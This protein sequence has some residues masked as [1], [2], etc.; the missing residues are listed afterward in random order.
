MAV[1]RIVGQEQAKH[2]LRRMLSADRLPHALLFHGPEGVGKKAMAVHLAMM[3]NCSQP[4]SKP[5]GTCKTCRLFGALQH[6]DLFVLH[7][8]PS[9]LQSEEEVAFLQA[10]AEHP[11]RV[12]SPARNLT[13]S[14]ERVRALQHQAALRPY[15]AR[16][17]VALIFDADQMRP[18]GANALLKT[19]EDPPNEML[20]ILTS[21]Y[22]EA[23]LPTIRSRCQWIRLL[24]LQDEEIERMLTEQ[25]LEPPQARLIARLAR[26]NLTRAYDLCER[27]IE[28]Y[29]GS[30]LDFLRIALDGDT[31]PMLS[32]AEERSTSRGDPPIE[33][34]FDVLSIW[35]RDLFLCRHGRMDQITHVDRAEEVQELSQR[36]DTQAIE[37]ALIEIEEALDQIARNVNLQ[38]ILIHLLRRLHA[39]S[40]RRE[41]GKA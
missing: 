8:S 35:L 32:V 38:W 1:H 2:M 40:V 4:T 30:A 3:V 22:P 29:R 11:Y 10:V 19:L 21:A 24:P 28:G 34:F 13:I 17:K 6:P 31:L 41:G 36:F 25:G 7:P 37:E 15:G 39:L 12:P 20:L 27:D 18:E 33:P 26:G 14:I 9:N 23:L 5:C 16:R